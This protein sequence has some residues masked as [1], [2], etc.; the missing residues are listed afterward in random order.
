MQNTM[1]L[2]VLPRAGIFFN[3]NFSYTNNLLP[4]F[5][6]WIVACSFSNATHPQPFLSNFFDCLLFALAAFLVLFILVVS[7]FCK[8]DYSND[9]S[10]VQ[11]SYTTL[12]RAMYGL[13]AL[14]AGALVFCLN[15]EINAAYIALVLSFAFR[16]HHPHKALKYWLLSF[17]MIFVNLLVAED[18]NDFDQWANAFEQWAFMWLIAALSYCIFRLWNRANDI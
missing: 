1:L 17:F 7:S 11:I 2:F 3:K 16:D 4:P 12:F 15:S 5:L 6:L 9:I 10:F 18:F 14:L 13:W 8:E